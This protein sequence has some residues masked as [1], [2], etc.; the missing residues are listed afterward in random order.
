MIRIMLRALIAVLAFSAQPALAQYNGAP[1]LAAPAYTL[2]QK[3]F[4]GAGTINV[5]DYKRPADAD[6]TP[7]FTRALATGKSV[8]IPELAGGYIISDAP[9]IAAPGQRLIG[10]G[11]SKSYLHMTAA[12]NLS[13]GAVVTVTSA[14]SESFAGLYDVGFVFD[15]PS[16]TT[17]A[18]FTQY[19]YAISLV[20]ASRAYL[21]GVIKITGAWNG[22]NATG[23]TGGMSA[24]SLQIGAANV[25]IAFD[26]ALDFVAI[27]HLACWPH[28]F[29]DANRIQAYADGTTTCATF[30][31]VDGL[32][33]VKMTAF[34][35]RIIFAT[36]SGGN[37]TFGA[38]ESLSLDGNYSR[39]DGAVD[40]LK[41]GN[42]Y[43]SSAIANDYAMNL[44]GGE[45][46]LGPYRM[47]FGAGGTTPFVL[48]AGANVTATTGHVD[49]INTGAPAF[50]ITSGTM[51]LDHPV[52]NYG[53]NTT[54]TA[55]FFDIAGGVATITK[56]RFAAIGSGSGTG[57]AIAANSAHMIDAPAMNGWGVTLPGTISAGFYNFDTLF[58]ASPAATFQT[59]GDATFNNSVAT[60]QYR[61]TGKHISFRTS[62]TFTTN[63][64]TT[65]SGAFSIITGIPYL[66]QY[67]VG[68]AMP[69]IANVTFSGYFAPIL[70]TSGTVAIRNTASAAGEGNFGTANIKASTAA[71]VTN[72]SGT[73]PF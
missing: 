56:P 48:V 25:G 19:P 12:F 23:N 70:G 26:G 46:E 14:V 11:P 63:A 22:I 38:I 58:A 40:H 54:R 16:V 36:G 59:V 67:P 32:Q 50:R 61:L 29:S 1:D 69:D 34:S 55:P 33:V 42:W 8:V 62:L 9:T 37:A 49:A 24:E 52:I 13:A 10:F 47:Y 7:A 27:K 39:I 51:T 57:I 35:S 2:A 5:T 20:N 41:I 6:W 44:T 3:A 72:V 60:T 28:G 30:G 45:W 66:P 21:G 43:K 68:L 53:A 15:Q 17:R 65:A 31:R 64:Y 71:I 73:Y 4:A 18:G